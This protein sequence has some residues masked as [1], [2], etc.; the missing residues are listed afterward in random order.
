[1]PSFCPNLK[2]V[3]E[4]FD[5]QEDER[6]VKASLVK[7]LD[8]KDESSKHPKA[9]YRLQLAFWLSAWDGYALAAAV[10]GQVCFCFDFM[11]CGSLYAFVRR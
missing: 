1:M 10:L 3:E 11:V 7:L 2:S 9:E 5:E 4:N 6:E 8:Q